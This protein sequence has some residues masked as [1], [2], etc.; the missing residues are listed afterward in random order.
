MPRRP[1]PSRQPKGREV[2]RLAATVLPGLSEEEMERAM[3]DLVDD[4]AA[5]AV[6]RYLNEH[7]DTR[8]HLRSVQ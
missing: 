7:E 2:R 4:L 8:R 5:L 3:L 6:T 1:A